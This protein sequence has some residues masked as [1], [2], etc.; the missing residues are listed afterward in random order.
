MQYKTQHDYAVRKLERMT[1]M[2]KE[3]VILLL[4]IDGRSTGY[5]QAEKKRNAKNLNLKYKLKENFVFN[6]H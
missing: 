4:Y 1:K 5:E 3:N 2:E 6:A